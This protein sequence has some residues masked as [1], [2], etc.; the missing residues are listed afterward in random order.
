MIGLV[1][2]G[3]EIGFWVLVSLGL[4]ARYLLRMP[5]VGLGFLVAAPLVDLVL[6][7]ATIVDLRGGATATTLHALAGVYIGVSVAF[8]HRMIAW[9]DA[10][11]AHRL[12]G[13]PP[14]VRRP[15]YG[16]A[17]ARAE[18]RT[19][20]RHL[21]AWAVGSVLLLAAAA[22]VGEASRTEALTG[23]VWHWAIIVA[24]DMAWSLSYTLHP[25]REPAA[26]R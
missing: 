15:R 5:R 17:H 2:V 4:V 19:W 1:I 8:G 26:G 24:I 6:L 10:R 3:C 16:A 20:Y 25:R 13:G 14:P 12:G 21:L 22:M 18:R 9:A 23:M 11:A 7:S